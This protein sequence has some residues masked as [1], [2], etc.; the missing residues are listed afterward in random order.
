MGRA[1]E[2]GGG[3]L[4]DERRSWEWKWA[5]DGPRALLF[6]S[7]G[8]GLDPPLAL[9]SSFSVLCFTLSCPN[10]TSSPSS[11]ASEDSSVVAGSLSSHDEPSHLP[12]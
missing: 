3:K 12:L 6:I 11:P 8:I 2:V 9:S 10:M 1:S 4:E 7:M 5:G